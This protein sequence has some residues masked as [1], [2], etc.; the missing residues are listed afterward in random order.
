MSSNNQKETL[1]LLLAV[2]WLAFTVTFAVW[3]FALGLG[4]VAEL[5]KLQPELS[6]HWSR[7]RRMIFFEGS[8]W[9]VLLVLGGAALIFLVQKERRTVKRIREFFASFSHEVKTAL[10]SLRLQAETLKDEPEFKD[11]TVLD[12]LVGDTVRL[13]LQLENSLFFA[14]Q[15]NLQLYLQPVMLSSVV[16]RMREQWPGLTIDLESNAALHADERALRTILSNLIQN[17][18]VHG[19]A[20]HVK[21]TATGTKDLVELRLKDNGSGFEGDADH[22][23]ELFYR[24]TPSSGSGL[25]LYICRF[26][27]QRMG[28]NLKSHN[29]DGGFTVE[30]QLQGHVL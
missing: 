17:A 14:S 23:G 6:E 25:G 15:E 5:A 12:R 29:E 9:I 4:Y 8:A 3:W 11:S 22:L 2:L 30:V 21:V 10:A 27:A 19:K 7:Q 16:D 1:K 28:G 13:Q 26:L 20:T 18:L 24:P